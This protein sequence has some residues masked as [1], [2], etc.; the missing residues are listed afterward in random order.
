MVSGTTPTTTGTVAQ[1]ANDLRFPLRTDRAVAIAIAGFAIS[2]V[3]LLYYRNF[4]AIAHT[5]ASAIFLAF[6]A[7]DAY[8]KR[9]SNDALRTGIAWTSMIAITATVLIFPAFAVVG[10]LAIV[11]GL[12]RSLSPT[13]SSQHIIVTS[14]IL[15]LVLMLVILA[16][17]E[18][19]RAGIIQI[20][21]TPFVRF[22]NDLREAFARYGLLITSDAPK[23]A[24]TFTNTVLSIYFTVA[25]VLWL[26]IYYLRYT[27]TIQ[28]LSLANDELTAAQNDLQKNVLEHTKLLEISRAVTMPQDMTDLLKTLVDSLRE[29]IEFNC[30]SICLIEGKTVRTVFSEG[31]LGDSSMVHAQFAA[32]PAYE[33]SVFEM[34]GPIVIADLRKISPAISGSLLAVPLI[35]RGQYRGFLAI[36]HTATGYYDAHA[37]EVCMGFANQVAT[38]ID[39]AHLREAASQALVTAERSRLARELHDSVSQSLY[40]IVLGTRTALHQITHAP[41]ESRDALEYSSNLAG[42]ALAQI[43]SLIFTLRPERLETVGIIGALQMQIELLHTHTSTRIRFDAPQEEPQLSLMQKEV[44]YRIAVDAIQSAVRRTQ[45]QPVAIRLHQTSD[46]IELAIISKNDG[47]NGTDEMQQHEIIRVMRERAA[48]IHAAVRIEHMTS[49]DSR[50]I[51]C[52]PLH[53]SA[54][55]MQLH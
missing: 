50:I 22:E 33:R 28:A 18:G 41:Q 45:G 39:A 21:I 27:T 36:G 19:T 26:R 55:L 52:A 30:A 24:I 53:P 49:S 32:H 47:S 16:A 31:S 2:A 48:A 38:A 23:I 13:R 3:G 10:A 25:I 1:N 6:V 34:R 54:Y 44:L 42:T 15:T 4:N 7:L 37:T 12:L 51:V 17:S 14:S 11:D 5:A 40:G 8:A 20:G 9:I 46:D 29:I 35:V 43:R